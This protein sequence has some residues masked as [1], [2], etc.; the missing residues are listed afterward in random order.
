MLPAAMGDFWRAREEWQ[1]TWSSDPEKRSLVVLVLFFLR[2]LMCEIL[3]FFFF[4]WVFDRD[5]V[6]MWQLC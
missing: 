3:M 6:K 4:F 1:P 5:S 2:Y